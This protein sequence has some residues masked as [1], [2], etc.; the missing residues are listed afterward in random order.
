MSSQQAATGT[1]E[2]MAGGVAGSLG[3]GAFAGVTGMSVAWVVG[4]LI[5]VVARE[6]QSKFSEWQS[7]AVPA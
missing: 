4:F 7:G 6:P 2:M 3:S 1:A 5:D